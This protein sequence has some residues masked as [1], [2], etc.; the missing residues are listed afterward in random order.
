MGCGNSKRTTVKQTQ[1][2]R[3]NLNMFPN[4]HQVFDFLE[5]R[6]LLTI[7]SVCKTFQTQS[8]LY[9]ILRKFQRKPL[10]PLDTLSEF[11]LPNEL[12]LKMTE[13]FDATPQ[14]L[15][16]SNLASQTVS[17]DFTATKSF[18]TKGLSDSF[19]AL[20]PAYN[21]KFQLKSLEAGMSMYLSA[22]FK[23]PIEP[24]NTSDSYESYQ[25]NYS[26]FQTAL[27]QAVCNVDMPVVRRLV[28]DQTLE[29]LDFTRLNVHSNA[30]EVSLVAVA[31]STGCEEL[32]QLLLGS[33][34][35]ISIVDGYKSYGKE[36]AIRVHRR[37]SPLQL[38][39]AKGY[40][41]IVRILL[42]AGADPNIGGVD[43][44]GPI[45][46]DYGTPPL[47]IVA[48]PRF[49]NSVLK[50]PGLQYKAIDQKSDYPACAKLLLDA[51]AKPDAPST[52]PL[53]PVP[54]FSAYFDIELVKEL[55]LHGANP[56]AT[57]DRGQT[58]VYFYCEKTDNVEAVILL[59]EYGAIH[60]PP[61]CRP[62]FIALSMRHMSVAQLLKDKGANINGTSIS[63]SALQVAISAN[64][65]DLVEM[66]L[67]WEDLE[68]DWLFRQNG[69]NMFHRIA[70]NKS[71]EI[72]MLIL[73]DKRASDRKAIKEALNQSVL[74]D[75][76]QGDTTPILFALPCLPLMKLFIEYGAD[77]TRL[78]LAKCCKTFKPDKELIQ[79]MLDSGLDI[80]SKY[81]GRSSLWIAY[82][83]GR[84]DIM[85]LL[86]K[87]GADLDSV[88][89]RGMTP[90]HDACWRGNFMQ[91]GL[92][93]KHGANRSLRCTEG[94]DAAA[95]AKMPYNKKTSELKARIDNL[96]SSS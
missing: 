86:A 69:K 43:Q 80:D 63:P 79:F 31:A 62:L 84:L 91:A 88:D 77:P 2:D 70:Q 8:G 18:A 19:D 26:E 59:I 20:L 32:L 93:L 55:L 66:I 21:M 13:S 24:T 67:S 17:R 94:R 6:E 83:D 61:T 89:E 16:P 76:L 78:S 34:S 92:L 15:S 14:F 65:T 48:N 60:D 54:L 3:R 40:S 82:E 47:H 10:K 75:W 64:D 11:D 58:P 87:S 42:K 44:A 50:L 71:L 7:A 27:L 53:T 85:L 29:S 36:F 96:L 73:K 4:W 9:E 1:I 25:A 68:V 72:C 45:M 35:N 33:F 95:Y 39:C 90:L 12:I 5:L 52:D 74:D 46:N 49:H 22:E 38:A 28:Q 57:N 41:G 37:I 23:S 81:E 30:E 56:N 51:G